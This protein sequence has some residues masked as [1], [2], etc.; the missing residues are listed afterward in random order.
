MDITANTVQQ[1]F[2]KMRQILTDYSV[3]AKNKGYKIDISN[4]DYEMLKL[5]LITYF[6]YRIITDRNKNNARIF[7]ASLTFLFGEQENNSYGLINTIALI[8]IKKSHIPLNRQMNTI[9]LLNKYLA[10]DKI[11]DPLFPFIVGAT[12]AL[13]CQSQNLLRNLKN[14]A[15][16]YITGNPEKIEEAT[17]KL[18]LSQYTKKL[19]P[20]L[21]EHRIKEVIQPYKWKWAKNL[22]QVTN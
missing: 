2:E 5:P 6:T 22:M 19:N 14:L 15:D 11:N 17:K 12:L 8:G 3:I 16:T 13:P 9:K 18:I 20:R 1:E 7:C 21:S 10:E 4:F